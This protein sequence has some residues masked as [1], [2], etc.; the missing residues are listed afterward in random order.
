MHT[1]VNHILA[2]GLLVIS[3]AS[4]LSQDTWVKVFGGSSREYINGFTPHSDGGYI[5]WGGTMGKDGD[6]GSKFW[7][8]EC[9]PPFIS[10]SFFLCRT[11]KKGDVIWR[12]VFGEQDNHTYLYHVGSTTDGGDIFVGRAKY[13]HYPYAQ[14][15]WNT[16]RC[17]PFLMDVRGEDD[18]LIMKVSRHGTLEWTRNIGGSKSEW[19][20]IRG[21]RSGFQ[22]A[23]SILLASDHLIVSGYT[24]SNDRDFEGMNKGECDVFLVC[25]RPDGRILWKKTFGGAEYDGVESIA[26]EGSALVITGETSSID[27]DFRRHKSLPG[28]DSFKLQIDTNGNLLSKWYPNGSEAGYPNDWSVRDKFT[29]KNEESIVITDTTDGPGTYSPEWK[30]HVLV[31]RFDSTRVMKTRNVIRGS[32]DDIGVTT[33]QAESGE[34][35]VVG[36]TSSD[37]GDFS[38]LRKSGVDFSG[39][40]T[41]DVFVAKYDRND[42]RIL[43]RKYGG[44]NTDEIST[45]VQTREGDLLLIGST[46]S[47]DGVFESRN[48]GESDVYILKIDS[49][50]Q[51]LWSR[52]YG[53]RGLDEPVTGRVT[54]DNGIMILG[55]TTSDVGDQF[56]DGDFNGLGKGQSDIFIMKLDANGNLKPTVSGSKTK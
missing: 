34:Y 38:G 23:S 16:Y 48:R 33:L 50:G 17:N 56:N 22:S 30:R 26:M 2:L 3:T 5:F 36:T 24:C 28:S 4:A 12:V 21:W 49:T 11:D 42:R 1:I 54:S 46:M 14:Y 20:Y 15:S 29:M 13:S 52:T 9:Y 6:F 55:T 45:V 35:Y 31:M 27:G 10:R 43:L 18:I 8:G 41:T 40:P 37:D 25:L 7:Q 44:S 32:G 47:D 51:V 39:N 19:T 53:G